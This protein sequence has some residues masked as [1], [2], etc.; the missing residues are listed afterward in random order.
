VIPECG[1][2]RSGPTLSLQW[3]FEGCHVTRDISSLI[4]QGKFKI[5]QL[6]TA[7]LAP[8]PKSGSYFFWGVALPEL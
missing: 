5:E 2:G 1:V 8:F 4:R 3:A 6:Y 7:Y